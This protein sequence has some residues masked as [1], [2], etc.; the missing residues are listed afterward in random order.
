MPRAGRCALNQKLF[1]ADQPEPLSN[2]VNCYASPSPVIEPGRVYV[3]FG[4][5]GTACLDTATCKTL[6][7]RT[8]LPCRH[9]RGPASSPILFEDL[10]ILSMDGVDVQYLVALNKHTGRTVWKTDR[11]TAWGD[12]D[13]DGKPNREGDLRKAFS[14]PLLIE[15]RGQPLLVSSGSKTI[16]GYEPRSGREIWKVFHGSHTSASRPVF[17]KGLVLFVTGMG[18]SELWAVKPDGQ[19][20]VTGSHVAWK[21]ASKTVS[22]TS[23]PVVVGDLL[24]M[25]SDGGMISCL[26]I[27][28]GRELWK[29]P[30]GRRVS[31][32]R[33]WPT[34]GSTSS[35]RRARPPSSSRAAHTSCWPPTPWRAVAWRRRSYRARPSSCAPKRISTASSPADQK[36]KQLPVLATDEHRFS[37]MK[38]R[39]SSVFHACSSVA[40]KL[41]RP[42]L[43]AV[44]VPAPWDVPGRRG[45]PRWATWPAA[46]PA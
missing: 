26:E 22:K 37:R 34:A 17:G 40:K 45:L 43:W 31:L 33:S 35:A 19:G 18:K 12:L 42:V 41:L 27:A 29:M 46:R 13:A 11:T 14:T 3:H 2:P 8:D 23:S 15:V 20:D 44:T 25:V 6:W 9:Y 30:L 21:S 7:R 5:Y 36:R 39:K 4:S 24:F 16:Y 1:H 38:K 10:L 28:T 32:R